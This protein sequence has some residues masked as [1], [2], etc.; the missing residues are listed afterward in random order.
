VIGSSLRMAVL[1]GAAVAAGSALAQTAGDSFTVE[2]AELARLGV[3]L[4]NVERV[5][6]IE[7]V[8]APAEVVV[9]PPR[10]ALVGTP[11]AGI[12]ARLL[13]AEGDGVAAQ[14]PLAEID[15]ADFLERQ[16]DYLDATAAAELAATQ[17]AR[18]RGLFDEGIIAERRLAETRAAA[19][20]ARSRLEQA[21]AQL[22]LAGLS[23]TDVARLASERKLATRIVLRAPFAGTVTAA[24]AGVG[25]R[26]EALAPVLTIADLRELWLIVR[27][28]QESAVHVAAG[29]SIAVAPPGA[30][31]LVGTVTAVGG[32]V[33]AA[34]QTVLVRGVVANAGGALRAGQ[35]LTARVRAAAAGGA[36]AV[37][38][39]AVTRDAGDA[40]VFV[41]AGNTMHVRR[42]DVVGDD[43]VRIYVDG[44]VGAGERIAV[45]GVSALKALWM[46]AA[47][48]EGG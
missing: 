33:D 3:A 5:E 16:R 30:P 20:A 2:D 14:Q 18:D 10:L 48:E 42:V 9:P 21:E 8:A 44:G 6:S 26:V 7:V 32:V 41:R 4:G 28:P 11:E 45:S 12:V 15:S 25:G 36:L 29:M 34:T 22:E 46:S 31:E 13:A 24:H 17:E 27:V 40:L 37:P 39:A 35:F 43:G 47:G 1:V 19:R 38:G 23:R